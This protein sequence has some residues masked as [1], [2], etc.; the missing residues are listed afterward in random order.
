[1]SRCRRSR[2]EV[3]LGSS[4]LIAGVMSMCWSVPA[5]A[6]DRATAVTDPAG[7]TRYK[8][9]GYMDIVRVEVSRQGHTIQ[10]MTILAEPIPA[11]P[12]LPPP[13]ND[14][15]AWAWGFDTDPTTDPKGY[16]FA[17]GVPAQAEFILRVDWDG[18]AFTG[19][20][21]DRRPLLTGQEAVITPRPFSIVSGTV[22]MKVD[23]TALGSPTSFLWDAVTTYFPSPPGSTSLKQAD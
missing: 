8:A 12:A 3:L 2:F 9:P 11:A 7:D 17:E 21:V 6:M 15:I 13:G 20:L 10:V 1:M 22:A 14:R 4:A 5:W 16:P 23:E 18:H 19:K